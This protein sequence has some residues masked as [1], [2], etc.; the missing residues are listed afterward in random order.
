LTELLGVVP[1][2]VTIAD[3]RSFIERLASRL[4]QEIPCAAVI[5]DT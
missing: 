5:G 3:A 1:P 4:E 2:D